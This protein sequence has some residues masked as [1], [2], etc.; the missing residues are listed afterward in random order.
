MMLP[1]CPAG[2]EAAAYLYAVIGT[3]ISRKLMSAIAGIEGKMFLSVICT[4]LEIWPKQTRNALREALPQRVG[5][6]LYQT[7]I[8]L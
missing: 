3:Q 7:N 4:Y 6:F 2:H 1:A 5:K 8:A